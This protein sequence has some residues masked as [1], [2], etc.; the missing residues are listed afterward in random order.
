VNMMQVEVR[1]LR[2]GGSSP[3]LAYMTIES[4]IKPK[5]RPTIATMWIRTRKPYRRNMER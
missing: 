2:V 4:S 1:L 5:L 3:R